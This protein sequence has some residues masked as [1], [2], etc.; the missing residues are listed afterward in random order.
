MAQD[1]RN[2]SAPDLRI[3]GDRITLQPS[4]F[5]EPALTGE[6]KEEALMRYGARFRSEPLRFLREVSLYVSGT[7]WRAYDDVIG[8]PIF[9]SGFSEHIK[10]QVMSAM[11]LQAKIAQLAD[12]R[13]TVE[14][15][16]G[17]LNKNDKDFWAKRAQRRSVLIQSLQEVAESMTDNMICKFDS[18]P[19]IRGAYYLVSQLLLRAYHQGI[20][21]SSEEVLRLRSVAE[22]AARK[23]QSII[24]LPC[25][26]S[27]VDYVSLQLLCYRLGLAL[28]VVVAGDNLNFPVVGSF[29]QHAGAMYIRRSFGDDQLYT[30]VV[31]T[32]IDVMLQGGY[33]LECFIE[34]GRSRT[35]KLLPPKF[36]ILSFVLDSL[37]SGRVEDAIIC[38]VSTQYDKVIETEG[39]VTELLGVPKK[40]ENL[41]DFLTN[42]SSVLSLRLGRVDVRFYEPWS[43]RGFIDE[44]LTRLSKVPSAVRVDWKD[45]KNQ[46][47][48]QKLLRTLG[49][50]VLADINAVSVVMPTALIGTVLL[51]LRGRG[52][53]RTELIRR[54]EW[55]TER[56]RAKG[57]RVAHFGNAPL[58]DVIE[59]GLEVLGKDLV[60]YVEGLA[61]PTYYAVD[62]FQLSFYRNMT[63]HLFISEALVAAALYTRV[64]QG[65]GPA[66]QDIPYKDLYDQVFFLSSLFRGEFIY[67]GEGLATNLEKT[68]LGLEADNVI[69]IERNEEGE[70]TKVGLSDAER[71]AGRENYDFYCFLIWPF[72]EASWLAAVSLMGLTPPLGQKDDIWLQVSKAQ[73]SAQLLGKTLYHQ[74]DLSYFEAVNKE[75]LK[76]SYQRFE[77]EGIIQVV[78]SKDTSIPPRLRIAPEWRPG[79][80]EKTG[81]LLASGRLW[82]FTEKI[83]SSRREGKNRRDGATVS[84][85]VIGLTDALGRKLFDDAVRGEEGKGKGKGKVA[86]PARLSSE[87]EKD[88]SRSVMEQRRR[89][90]LEGRAHL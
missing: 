47:V 51:T 74:G 25:H 89:R 41:A 10:S 70:I 59:R 60:G 55:L 69:F 65:G 3:L 9:Y 13:I 50:R 11:V 88:L 35:G 71:A 53:G 29:L 26:R 84:T 58:P 21:V 4:G 43:L 68:V 14:E 34:G 40:K 36:G 54:V 6:G 38:P 17:L 45:M 33:N 8:Q 1:N 39:Y 44:Q 83:A 27:H 77:E 48:R 80:D 12:M 66:I 28:P 5:V 67:S 37:L 52:V 64:K 49:Y 76:N 73:E 19:F 87:E 42:G 24:F 46:V 57:G 7:G 62:R 30:A 15:K 16:E 20:H 90:R 32:Y 63:I 78:K 85:R 18:K 56:I 61:E 79:R 23:K 2:D 86:A 72:I 75:T 81:R 31:Q 82:D 22:E